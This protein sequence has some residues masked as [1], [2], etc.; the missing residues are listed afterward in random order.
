MA[1]TT[2]T[3]EPGDTV[4]MTD[5]DLS[6]SSTLLDDGIIA[7]NGTPRLRLV[8]G[9]DVYA[10]DIL[11]KTYLYFLNKNPDS[12]YG[13]FSGGCSRFDTSG[14][15]IAC[16]RVNSSSYYGPAEGMTGQQF[17]YAVETTIA[18]GTATPTVTPTP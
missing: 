11:S 4:L 9:G 6:V 13:L 12:T 10:G 8:D 15:V 7:G 17:V 1:T 16:S 3:P 18:L 5:Y 14:N 2:I